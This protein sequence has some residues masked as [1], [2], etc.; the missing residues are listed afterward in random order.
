M[1]KVLVVIVVAALVVGLSV[2]ASAAVKIVRIYFDSTGAD[3]G[4]NDRLSREW[5]HASAQRR[6]GTCGS[7][8]GAA[9]QTRPPHVMPPPSSARGARAQDP[10]PH[11]PVLPHVSY[12]LVRRSAL[13]L[14]PFN[15]RRSMAKSPNSMRIRLNIASRAVRQR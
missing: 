8:T 2:D 14:M 15:I 10:R 3:T 13:T 4:T 5:I 6:A 12:G 1:R 9:G 11:L 7:A